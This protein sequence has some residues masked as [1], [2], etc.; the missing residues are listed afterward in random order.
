[1]YYAKTILIEKH[2]EYNKPLRLLFTDIK[3]V[4][5]SI[6]RKLLWKNMKKSG[7]PSKLV[8]M[9]KTCIE[10]SRRKIKFGNN[11]SEKFDTTVGLKQ[12][13]SYHRRC[14]TLP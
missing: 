1:M 2:Y 14:L 11:Y 10:G 13:M 5:D 7:I 3:Q 9:M 8:R 12:E 4:Y 6:K